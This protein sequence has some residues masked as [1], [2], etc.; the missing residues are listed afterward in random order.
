VPAEASADAAST[1]APASAKPK[2][3]ASGNDAV[4]T[5]AQKAKAQRAAQRKKV[6]RAAKTEKAEP[7]EPEIRIVDKEKF[8]E[9]GNSDEPGGES[10]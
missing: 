2:K 1:S 5:G 9:L 8:D 4:L 10:K 6:G 3:A 7:D